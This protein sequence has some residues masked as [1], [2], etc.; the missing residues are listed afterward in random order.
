MNTKL[1][2]NK[3]LKTLKGGKHIRFGN[4]RIIPY[5]FGMHINKDNKVTKAIRKKYRGKTPN[6]T[7]Y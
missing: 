6:I 3:C 2:F 1:T 7:K 5:M 4:K